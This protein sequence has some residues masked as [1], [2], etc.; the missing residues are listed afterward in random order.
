V[1]NSR[2][3]PQEEAMTSQSAD[4]L[5]TRL[6]SGRPTRRRLGM[7]ALLLASLCLLTPAQSAT[8]GGVTVPDTLPV[9]GH[10]LVLNGVGIRT[11]TFL[12]VKIYVAALYVT[13]K[14]NNPQT[15][16]SSPGPTVL[17][18]HYIHSG[19]KEQVQDRYREGEKVNCGDGSC[20]ASLQADFEKLVASA[21]PVNEGDTTMF[22]VTNKALRVELN[23]KPVITIANG[24]LANMILQGFIGP[25][26]PSE[27]LRAA[28]LGMP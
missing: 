26:P 20:D 11:L 14:T 5:P 2:L 9:D 25:H 1:I 22:I 23:G 10:N 8:L 13:T 6:P 17:A 21:T 3:Q 18:L 28:L 4:R 12:K 27:D 24:R 19:S 7:A 15:I 16:L